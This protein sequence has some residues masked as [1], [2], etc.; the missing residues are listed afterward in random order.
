MS[1]QST[2]QK[3]SS[4]E[5]TTLL[6]QQ[7]ELLKAFETKFQ[8]QEEALKKL[9]TQVQPKRNDATREMTDDDA[10]NILT[11]DLAKAKHKDA[12]AKLGL[13]Y[14]QVY[15]CRLEFTFKHIHKEMKAK[16]IKNEWMK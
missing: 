8:I 16:G 12:A 10:R 14:G 13:S 4:I 15:S 6:L 3:L 2:V 9:E 7:Q 11:G 5:L 1:D